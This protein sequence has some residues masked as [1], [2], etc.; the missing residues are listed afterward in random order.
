MGAQRPFRFACGAG[1]VENCHVIVGVQVDRRQIHIFQPHI[2][3]CL[4]DQIFKSLRT[5]QFLTRAPDANQATQVQA[6]HMRF[7]FLQLPPIRDHNAGA[8]I[9]N[10][11]V[12]FRPGPPGIQRHNDRPDRHGGPENHRPFR[13]VAHDQGHAV[14]LFHPI[15]LCQYGREFFDRFGVRG[16]GNPFVL[17]HHK[18]PLGPGVGQLE[19]IAQG[20]R[21]VFIGPRVDAANVHRFHFERCA[22]RR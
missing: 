22:G 11:I 10:A 1:R 2:V 18:V 19:H 13:I 8:G 6:I 7:Q 3:R 21:R 4:T 17:I 15:L 20:C 12:H 16:E 14:T 5:A 9:L